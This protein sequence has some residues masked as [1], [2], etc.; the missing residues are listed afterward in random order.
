MAIAPCSVP[1]SRLVSASA[2]RLPCS[3][4]WPA[5]AVASA[6]RPRT[7]ASI[8]CLAVTITRPAVSPA[9]RAS[10]SNA[11]SADSASLTRPSSISA[12]K[13][14]NSPRRSSSGSAEA[15]ASSTISAAAVSRS[16]APAGIPQRV[17]PGVKHL[18]EHGR[19]ITAAGQLQRVS[20]QPAAP[21][22]RGR[23]AEQRPGQ[24]GQQPR[25]GVLSVLSVLSV[26]GVPGV[27]GVPASNPA[28]RGLQQPDQAHVD[29]QEAL[30]R[31][32]EQRKLHHRITIRRHPGQLGS[33][34][35]GRTGQAAGRRPQSLPDLR[36]PLAGHLAY[37]S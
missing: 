1:A 8:A 23:V 6:K 22:G 2:A 11:A 36:T 27:P 26:P 5:R 17:Q 18:G 32:S 4:T 21:G 28:Q 37:L 33:Q 24:P 25:P 20:H 31:L 19:V 30:G 29:V 35:P 7:V 16:P 9:A 3:A 13:R 15:R 34:R 12:T 10:R 14:Q